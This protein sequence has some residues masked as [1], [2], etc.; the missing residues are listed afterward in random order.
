MNNEILVQTIKQW[1]ELEEKINGLSKEL[2]ILRKTKKDLNVSLINV[3]KEHE[4]DCFDC[5]SGQ[6]AYTRNN[7]KKSINQ[8]YL[9]NILNQ[10]FEQN[11][12]E[13]ADKICN[14]ILENRDTQVRENIKL[15]KKKI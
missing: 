3:M 5:N 10:Y 12:N 6:L 11:N 13:E 14:Y 8:K 7:V 15:K 2:R 1:I 9:I 4:I